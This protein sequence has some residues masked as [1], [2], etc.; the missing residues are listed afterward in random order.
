MPSRSPLAAVYQ[1]DSGDDRQLAAVEAP[2]ARE[3]FTLP[4][5]AIPEQAFPLQLF[6]VRVLNY[7]TNHVVA[8]V[9][10]FAL[11]RL[12]YRYAVGIRFGQQATVFLGAYV[13]FH[14]PRDTRRTGAAIGR[15][16][17]INRDCTL[18]IRSGLT[19][20]DNVSISPEVMI[21]GGSHD[22]ND[23][24]FPDVNPGPTLIEDHAFIGS[25]ALLLGGVTVG[26]GA[27]VAAGSV[28]T[29]DVPAMTIVA[30]VPAKPVGLRDADATAYELGGPPPL[31]E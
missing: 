7:L 25:R 19:I 30:G 1:A 21:L 6:C 4:R 13:W 31:F 23:P 3:P 16:T 29:K 17:R 10:S 18:D 20:G 27:V 22:V 11:R 26:R 5:Q 12:W 28:V 24:T 9:P 2:P 8:H 15:N 14:G